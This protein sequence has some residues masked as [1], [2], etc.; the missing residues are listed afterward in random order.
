M[1]NGA[2]YGNSE[3]MSNFPRT[4][5]I[6]GRNVVYHLSNGKKIHDKRTHFLQGKDPKPNRF[7]F[8]HPCM[9]GVW[10]IPLSE[11][12]VAII[13]EDC[14][15]VVK[16]RNWGLGNMGYPKSTFWNTDTKRQTTV[17]IHKLIRAN[18]ITVDH[19]NRNKRDN[20]K[21]NLREYEGSQNHYNSAKPK[22]G[23][24]TYKGVTWDKKCKMWRSVS[25]LNK[26]AVF[27]GLFKCEKEG[28]RAYNEFV[29]KNHG[30][31][32]W[33]NPVD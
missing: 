16:G 26:K 2:L 17:N 10:C 31:F 27:L 12:Q 7:M 11:T 18:I 30:E 24:N 19:R 33:T 13:D 1:E 32:A 25:R 4:E 22:K 9:Q 20:R 29:I 23:F 21:C 28:A 14:V 3:K 15:D 6:D 8:P 5:I